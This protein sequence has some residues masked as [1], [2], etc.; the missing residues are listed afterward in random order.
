MTA[1]SITGGTIT[2]SSDTPTTCTVNSATG[3]TALTG[4][5]AGNCTVRAVSSNGAVGTRAVTINSTIINT[6]NC[7]PGAPRAG[8]SYVQSIAS[9]TGVYNPC[10]IDSYAVL[11][12]ET[13]P[14]NP[15]IRNM[16]TTQATFNYTAGSGSLVN[17]TTSAVSTSG[18]VEYGGVPSGAFEGWVPVPVAAGLPNGP[19][20]A[21]VYV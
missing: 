18:T 4:Q 3:S 11:G 5:G 21:D 13:A 17:L 2:Y 6:V 9:R 10:R 8:D 19:T 7:A 1:A 16:K 15:I 14:D 20:T 12:N